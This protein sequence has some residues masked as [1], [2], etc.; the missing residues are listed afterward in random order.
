MYDEEQTM[1]IRSLCMQNYETRQITN[2]RKYRDREK[3][4]KKAFYLSLI[5]M[6]IAVVSQYVID[7][8]FKI[9]N[10]R[11]FRD[12]FKVTYPWQIYYAAVIS[13]AINGILVVYL[14]S[15]PFAIAAVIVATIVYQTL[16]SL[17]NLT[18]LNS[19]QLTESIVRDV[20]IILVILYIL[21]RI[22][23]KDEFGNSKSLFGNVLEDDDLSH[24]FVVTLVGSVVINLS[25]FLGRLEYSAI[26][27]ET[28]IDTGIASHIE[29]PE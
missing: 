28:A 19:Q 4:R 26:F 16:A 15:K 23:P 21:N 29:I 10:G 17:T 5:S 27:G 1:H 2:K 7:V 20:F 14:P 13:G 25:T 24:L 11:P 6:A 22:S 3:L 12:W 8:V 18:T 9:F